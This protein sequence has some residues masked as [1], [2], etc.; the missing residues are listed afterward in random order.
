MDTVRKLDQSMLTDK[1]K[2]NLQNRM[3]KEQL[4]DAGLVKRSFINSSL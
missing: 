4:E 3:T 1:L 2:R